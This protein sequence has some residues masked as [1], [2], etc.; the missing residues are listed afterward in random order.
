MEIDPANFTERSKF[1]LKFKL[2]HLLGAT[3]V[4][5][6][7]LD[8][9]A[10]A[11][12]GLV[13]SRPIQIGYN[14][15]LRSVETNVDADWMAWRAVFD[16]DVQFVNGGLV[17]W[18]HPSKTGDLHAQ[19]SSSKLMRTPEPTLESTLTTKPSRSFVCTILSRYD[20]W[21]KLLWL[22]V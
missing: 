20:Q 16:L 13:G 17:S 2:L 5:S 22:V 9:W 12:N 1:R 18:H 19:F 4:I 11:S 7:F 14:W 10:C 6:F 3:A 15:M 21:T 8:R